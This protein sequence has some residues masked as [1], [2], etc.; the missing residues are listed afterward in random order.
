MR[1]AVTGCSNANVNK[2]RSLVSGINSCDVID[3]ADV[4]LNFSHNNE[5][6]GTYYTFNQN[7]SILNYE[8]RV[9]SIL[10]GERINYIR[11][12]SH[13]YRWKT[14]YIIDVFDLQVIRVMARYSKNKNYVQIKN[15]SLKTTKI[16]CEIAV[17]TLYSLGLDFG[18]VTVCVSNSDTKFVQSIEIANN[19]SE[20]SLGLWSKWINREKNL[21][22]NEIR[23]VEKP[24]TESWTNLKLGADPEFLLYDR[25]TRRWLIASEYFPRNGTVGTDD[26]AIYYPRHGYPLAEL[27]PNP[28]N[29]PKQLVENIRKTMQKGIHYIPCNN[30]AW[31]AG[32][33]PLK[34]FSIGV[35]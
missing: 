1:V 14:K 35:L 9:E 7:I 15:M 13:N 6:L 5:T 32:S 26:R 33:C 31:I 12:D 27:R 16:V 23:F 3:K 8:D 17:K 22:S 29:N 4:V 10:K 11:S 30:V 25:I 18:V 2:L 24:K 28:A 34:G 20:R 21:W 19:L